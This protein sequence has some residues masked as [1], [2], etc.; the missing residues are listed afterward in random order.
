MASI[1]YLPVTGLRAHPPLSSAA[2][3]GELLFVSGTPGF[4]SQG[5]LAE[6]DF[7]SQF[8]LAVAA[9]RDTLERGG[10]SLR[11]IIKLNMLLTREG[12]VAEMN[13]LY[14]EA[15]GPAPYP[16]RTTCVVKALPHPHMLLEIECVAAVLKP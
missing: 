3:F 16:A 9:L 8:A 6:G 14:A 2:R 4:D 11:S 7:A 12:D 10:S 1:E 5:R 13:R 15:F